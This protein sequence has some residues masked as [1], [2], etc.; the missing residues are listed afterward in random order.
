VTVDPEVFR[1]H[2]LKYTRIA[3]QLLPA[4]AKPAVL[5]AGCGTGVPTIELARLCDGSI[6]AV[7][8][9]GEAVRRLQERIAEHRLEQRVRALQCSFT[10]LPPGEGP[11]DIVWAE[12]SVSGIGFGSALDILGSQLR[13]GGFLVVHDEEGDCLAKAQAAREGGFAVRGLFVLPGSLWWSEYYQRLEAALRQATA[14]RPPFELEG[15]RKEVA[16]VRSD[17]AR[18]G[19]AY[20]IMRKGE[21]S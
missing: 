16:K 4:I 14:A 6:L 18:Y 2:L 10:A 11:F 12:G 19:S 15:L 7:D 21:G 13:S 9:D 3:F 5:D 8:T 17:P 1:A 20:F